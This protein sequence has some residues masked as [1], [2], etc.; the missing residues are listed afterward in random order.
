MCLPIGVDFFCCS[1]S[2]NLSSSLC[3]ARNASQS[4]QKKNNQFHVFTVIIRFLQRTKNEKKCNHHFAARC[5]QGKDL[6]ERNHHSCSFIGN[7]NEKNIDIEIN[8]Y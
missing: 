5:D 4:Q 3:N 6:M 2:D 1:S 8:I 7:G